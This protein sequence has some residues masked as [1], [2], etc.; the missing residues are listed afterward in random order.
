M[1]SQAIPAALRKGA[2]AKRATITQ[3]QLAEAGKA[4]DPAMLK[5]APAQQ[6][7]LIELAKSHL[8]D[9]RIQCP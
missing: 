6:K 1:L 2:D 4:A 3:L 9:E 7:I 8:T 5:R